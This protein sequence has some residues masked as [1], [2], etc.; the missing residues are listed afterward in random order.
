MLLVPKEEASARPEGRGTASPTAEPVKK[1]K[2]P[3]FNRNTWVPS[4]WNWEGSNY[5][6]EVDLAGQYRSGT[7]GPG[8]LL[9]SRKL[10]H[11]LSSLTLPALARRKQQYL[12][13]DIEKL[14]ASEGIDSNKLMPR[15]P[16]LQHPQTI[17]QGCDPLFPIY[18]PL[19]VSHTAMTC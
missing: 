7:W 16:D 17:E 4:P 6:N 1:F 19:K 9:T 14:L 15:H 8:S 3:S 11:E 2:Q 10:L 5:V 12:R 13:L 18:L